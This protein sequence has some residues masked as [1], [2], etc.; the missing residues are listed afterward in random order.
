MARILTVSEE[1]AGPQQRPLIEKA[2][3]MY[4]GVL[5]GILKIRLADPEIAA[6][7]FQI[8]QH[9]NLRKD[10][11]LTRLQREM[12]ATVVNGLVGGAP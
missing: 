11:S 7:G 5:P 4:G 2:K 12:T 10:S 8:Y 1:N 9:L 6:A 3:S